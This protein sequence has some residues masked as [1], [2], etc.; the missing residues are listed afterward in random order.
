[1]VS[2]P[3]ELELWSIVSHHVGTWKQIHTVCK[4]KCSLPLSYLSLAQGSQLLCCGSGL[5]N[6]SYAEHSVG[7]IYAMVQISIFS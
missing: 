1:M 4:N 7:I 2:D 5:S 6:K 3:L